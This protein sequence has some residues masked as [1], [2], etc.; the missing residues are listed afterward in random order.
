MKKILISSGRAVLPESVQ[1][2]DLLIQ[3]EKIKL[4]GSTQIYDEVIDASNLYILPGLIDIHY[5]GLFMFPDPKKIEEQLTRMRILLAQ[6]GVAGLLATFPAMPAPALCDCLAALQE[7]GK[8]QVENGAHL[9]GVHLEGPFLSKD[10]K[11]AQPE[12]AI[13][14][15][16]PQSN[17]MMRIFEAGQ[18]AGQDHDL[19]AGAKA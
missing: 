2:I 8:K 14:E 11:G 9:L 4:V 5:H 15:F 12:N 10:A 19:C 6:S 13:V 18:G 7:A 16:D 17:E 3:G 1:E